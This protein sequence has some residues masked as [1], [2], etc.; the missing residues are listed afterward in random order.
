V[1]TTINNEKTEGYWF[2]GDFV[3]INEKIFENV[4]AN[5]AAHENKKS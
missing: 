4:M 5:T 1:H 2:Y 3:G